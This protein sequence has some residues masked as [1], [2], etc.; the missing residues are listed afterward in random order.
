MY[1]KQWMVLGCVFCF[2]GVALG[3]FG[4]HALKTVLDAEGK[5]IFQTGVFYHFV[6]ALALLALGLF[7]LQFPGLDVE[8]AGLALVLG[9]V[10]FSGS[11]YVLAL[12]R[13]SFVGAI[14]PIGGLCFLYAWFKFAFLAWRA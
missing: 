10:L 9:I 2:F 3:A 5:A 4:A 8:S 14:T 7:K 12:T 6:H 11:L 1:A 13:I